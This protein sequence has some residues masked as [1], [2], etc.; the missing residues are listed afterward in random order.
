MKIVDYQN[1]VDPDLLHWVAKRHPLNPD[2][3][4][5]I[6][7][8]YVQEK[9]QRG[10][11]IEMDH[12][13]GN[14]TLTIHPIIRPTKRDEYILYHEFGHI[15]DRLNPDFRYNQDRRLALS[16]SQ[17]ECFLQIWNVFID[18]RLHHHGLFCLPQGGEVDI[19][20]DG[21]KYRLPRSEISTYLLEACAHLS[22]RGVRKPGALLTDIWNNPERHLTFEDLLAPIW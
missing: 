21:I 2:I 16:R 19:V 14:V 11:R 10:I 13:S 3:A 7:L 17:E 15:A 22:Q 5:E 18:A 6:P 12:R 20:V 9:D 1:L 8:L 4:S